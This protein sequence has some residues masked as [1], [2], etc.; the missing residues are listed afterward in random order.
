M[1]C[2]LF[3]GWWQQLYIDGNFS[4]VCYDPQI[5]TSL[6]YLKRTLSLF[7]KF[8]QRCS[9]KSGVLKKFATFTGKQRDLLPATYFW[10]KRFRHFKSAFLQ[11]ISRR[12]LVH[13]FESS[14]LDFSLDWNTD[15][16]YFSV[17]KGI[18]S[19]CYYFAKNID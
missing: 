1:L 17:N 19:L 7:K 6:N 10:K 18:L 8:I 11:N 15:V 12:L 4:H 13:S 3:H 16:L 14:F 9:L 2:C 5:V